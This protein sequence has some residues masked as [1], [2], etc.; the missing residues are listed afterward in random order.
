MLRYDAGE[1]VKTWVRTLASMRSL[2]MRARL[3]EVGTPEA[4]V[5]RIFRRSHSARAATRER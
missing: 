2:K 3:V 5:P 4:C 1:M